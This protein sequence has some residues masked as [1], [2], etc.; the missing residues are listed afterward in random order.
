MFFFWLKQAKINIWNWA[1][2]KPY[3]IFKSIFLTR[4][5]VR[6]QV[7]IDGRELFKSPQAL[8][9]SWSTLSK[10]WDWKLLPPAERGVGAESFLHKISKYLT[11][12]QGWSFCLNSPLIIIET[13]ESCELG[14]NSFSNSGKLLLSW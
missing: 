5:I 10:I 8:I 6:P 12:R 2:K 14:Q 13:P 9:F 1:L 7:N 4:N 3:F 11:Q